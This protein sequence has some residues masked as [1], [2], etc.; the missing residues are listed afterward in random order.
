MYFSFSTFTPF[1]YP[2][3]VVAS[4]NAS[5]YEFV[6]KM[7]PTN[8]F[9]CELGGDVTLVTKT[10][11]ENMWHKR[12][13]KFEKCGGYRPS[14]VARGCFQAVWGTSRGDFRVSRVPRGVLP[15]CLGYPG[16]IFPGCLGSP[17]GALLNSG[18][19]F[20]RYTCGCVTRTCHI[21][22]PEPASDRPRRAL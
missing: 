17:G 22:G 1:I 19:A 15:G 18:V 7:F 6:G 10:V 4:G 11:G 3:G 13:V 2:P 14:R 8:S 12:R 5:Q 20:Q 16:R 21:S 9:W